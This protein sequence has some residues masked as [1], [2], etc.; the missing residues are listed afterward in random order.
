MRFATPAPQ[1]CSASA[2]GIVVLGGS[3]GAIPALTT[4]LRALP[5]TFE[6]PVVVAQHLPRDPQSRLPEILGRSTRLLV[7]WAIDG[8]RLRA[9][10]VYVAP[11]NLVT[12]VTE[13]GRFA[14]SRGDHLSLPA[15]DP[16]LESSAD[17]Y[18]ERAIAVILSGL[19]HDGAR[20]VAAIRAQ[21]G[22]AIAQDE[23]TA[24]EFDM[25]AASIDLGRADM[26]LPPDKI[27]AALMLFA[28]DNTAPVA[29]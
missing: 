5:R 8:C 3:A 6:L 27:A 19:L 13:S 28:A 2:R 29:A 16:L 14:M 24:A 18:G 25:P 20:G 17:A 26:V 10:R 15:I 7:S 11:A 21:G 9:G 12:R 23:R 22:L 1:L 4:I